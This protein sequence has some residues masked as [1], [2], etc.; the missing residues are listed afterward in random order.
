MVLLLSL[1]ACSV[2]EE[3]RAAVTTRNLDKH[4]TNGRTYAMHTLYRSLVDIGATCSMPYPQV[5]RSRSVLQ[6]P[7]DLDLALGNI[8]QY[9][10]IAITQYAEQVR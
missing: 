4:Y 1:P 7:Q 8:Q 5:S 3:F 9:I 10:H 6:S 2:P